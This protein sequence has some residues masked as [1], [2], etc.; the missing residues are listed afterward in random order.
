MACRRRGCGLNHRG[1]RIARRRGGCLRPDLRHWRAH[2][3]RGAQVVPCRW[4][5]ARRE[6][7]TWRRTEI[8]AS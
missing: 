7:V 8:A 6:P 4:R 2:V 5:V 3:G 1:M